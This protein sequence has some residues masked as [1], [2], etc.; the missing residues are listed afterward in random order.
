MPSQDVLTCISKNKDFTKTLIN[1]SYVKHKVN[2]AV[3]Y[4]KPDA[5][6]SLVPIAS[7]AIGIISFDY[8]D[9]CR[10]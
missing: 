9:L 10:P 3:W 6:L 2:D 4:S 5:N 1:Y 7:F 8:V